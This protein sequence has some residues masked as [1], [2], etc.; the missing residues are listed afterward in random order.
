MLWIN[1]LAALALTLVLC[2][3]FGR[4]SAGHS[5]KAIMATVIIVCSG[6]IAICGYSF[7]YTLFTMLFRWEQLASENRGIIMPVAVIIISFFASVVAAVFF[8]YDIA[9]IA[10][11][12]A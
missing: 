5:I 11:F 4:Q 1:L 12:I 7:F 9:G 10:W 3:E 2:L 6:V 8:Y